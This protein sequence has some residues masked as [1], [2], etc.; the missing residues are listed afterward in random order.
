MIKDDS[1]SKRLNAIKNNTKPE[2]P[3]KEQPIKLEENVSTTDE[4]SEEDILSIENSN[5]SSSEF[6]KSLLTILFPCIEILA[7]GY[8]F[9]LLFMHD[10]KFLGILALGITIFSL[11]Y[12]IQSYFNKN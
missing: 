4:K 7:Y 11:L 5:S 8:T 10:L 3:Q 9:K 1:L 6:I 2:S 12:K